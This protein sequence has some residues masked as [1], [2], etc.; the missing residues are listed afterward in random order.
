M[1]YVAPT[2]AIRSL[3]PLFFHGFSTDSGGFTRATIVLTVLIVLNLSAPKQRVICVYALRF[4]CRR[5]HR[6][7]IAL[8]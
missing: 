3:F 4:V 6:K 8:L 1:Y 2:S 7:I 5:E